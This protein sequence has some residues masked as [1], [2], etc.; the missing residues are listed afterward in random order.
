M[1]LQYYPKI[2]KLEIFL[3]TSHPKTSSEGL[4]TPP[5]S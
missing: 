4:T 2:K 3:G 5:I 1:D